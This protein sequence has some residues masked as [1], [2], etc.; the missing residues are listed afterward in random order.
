MSYCAEDAILVSVWPRTVKQC[1]RPTISTGYNWNCMYIKIN[2]NYSN[3]GKTFHATLTQMPAV[4]EPDLHSVQVWV[5]EDKARLTIWP[6]KNHRAQLITMQLWLIAISKHVHL[7]L[8]LQNMCSGNSVSLTNSAIILPRFQ[9]TFPRLLI[10][11]LRAFRRAAP[12]ISIGTC[13]QP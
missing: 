1:I 5:Q 11:R 2:R 13:D 7:L 8:P 12:P 10:E 3:L 4:L 6:V 9:P